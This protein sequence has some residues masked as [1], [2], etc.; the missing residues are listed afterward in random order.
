MKT[1]DIIAYGALVVLSILVLL[2]LGAATY[3]ALSPPRKSDPNS[4][5]K[6]PPVATRETLTR[7][8]SGSEQELWVIKTGQD[9]LTIPAGLVGPH[10]VQ[11]GFFHLFLY[12]PG[13]DPVIKSPA[14]GRTTRDVVQILLTVKRQYPPRPIS[15][16]LDSLTKSY[17]EPQPTPDSPG[18]REYVHGVDGRNRYFLAV[19][20]SPRSWPRQ[21]FFLMCN[22][23][24]G[25]RSYIDD[26]HNGQV[27]VDF[28]PEHLPNAQSLF[29]D[30]FALLQSFYEPNLALQPTR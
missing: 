4:I 26:I 24:F 2:I 17:G 6:L 25:C 8:V 30:I 12:W 15:E 18:M 16:K 11:R 5:P 27:L 13:L 21:P 20:V 9:V 14:G 10:D 23:E 22:L 19:D 1:L 28:Y 29:R 3:W 7:I